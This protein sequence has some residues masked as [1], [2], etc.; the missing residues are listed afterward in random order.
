MECKLDLNK[1]YAI[2]L[3]G[4]GA[5]GA[6][7]VGAWR[8][9]E[10]AGV[11]YNAVSGSSVGALNG[12][13]MAMH[14]REEAENLWSNICFSQI[15]NVDDDMMQR[16]MK[17]EIHG[18]SELKALLKEARDVVKEG[19][20]DI[21]PLRRRI[22]QLTDEEKIRKSDVELFV[23]TYSL[24]DRKELELNARELQPGELPDMLLASAYFPAFKNEKLGGKRYADGGVQDV[25]PLHALLSHGYRDIIAIRLHGVGFE[26]RV[27]IPKNA[28]IITIS[29]NADLGGVLNFDQ[30]QSR[31]NLRLG[32][33]DAQR[34]LYG[35]RGKTY[36][37]E[38][39]F[40]E[41]RAYRE[42]SAMM[43]EAAPELS[44]RKLN[45]KLL[46]DLGR[47]LGEKGDYY[48]LLIAYLEKAAGELGIDPFSVVTDEA[49]LGLVW[50]QYH[51]KRPKTGILRYLSRS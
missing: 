51:I 39:T 42:L 6:Y 23:M 10:E 7:Q 16:L 17:R 24:S 41:E 26:R 29:P 22:A 49:L 45:E 48:D 13:M 38:K 33:F 18:F 2:A 9:L 50:E 12:A 8:A 4:G 27:R 14:A 35:L 46:H 30:E 47:E 34:V 32:Y 5:R 20:F 3:E 44:L 25:L 37:I 36:Y 1:T 31:A 40:D 21:E 15:M 43:R 19:G 28:G 11:R